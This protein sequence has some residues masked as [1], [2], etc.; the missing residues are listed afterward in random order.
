MIMEKKPI[1][2]VFVSFASIPVHLMLVIC[3]E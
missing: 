3:S 2:V 1:F